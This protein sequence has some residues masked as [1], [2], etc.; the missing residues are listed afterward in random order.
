MWR[1]MRS[2]VCTASIRVALA[3]GFYIAGLTC[4]PLR[5]SD[6]GKRFWKGCILDLNHITSVRS[7]RAS[8]VN[9]PLLLVKSAFYKLYI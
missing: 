3:K 6:R 1:T 5:E 7:Q 4:C 8:S 9:E 2:L